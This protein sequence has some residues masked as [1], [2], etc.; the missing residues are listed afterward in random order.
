MTD[1]GH[2][3]SGTKA[4]SDPDI[5]ISIHWGNIFSLFYLIYQHQMSNLPPEIVQP[6]RKIVHSST[7]PTDYGT[8]QVPVI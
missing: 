2:P 8:P 4:L 5:E 6:T 3:R 7:R 1:D